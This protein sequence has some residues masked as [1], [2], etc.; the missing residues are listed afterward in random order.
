MAS[1][2][3]Q[4]AKKEPAVKREPDT[5]EGLVF[6]ST[7]EFVRGISLDEIV[8]KEKNELFDDDEE[9]KDAEEPEADTKEA[10]SA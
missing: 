7:G 1:R 6:T 9:M 2:A 4:L 8:K 10:A 5:E 3:V